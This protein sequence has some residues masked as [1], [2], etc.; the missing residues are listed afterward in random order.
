MF[1]SA[2]MKLT[3]I[4]NL[5]CSYCYM[6]NLHDRTFQRVPTYLPVEIAVLTLDRVKDYMEE[7]ALPS[8]TLVLHGGEPTLWPLESFRTF[9]EHLS[10]MRAKGTDIRVTIQTNAYQVNWRVLDLLKSHGITLGISLD[11]PQEYNDRHRVNHAGRGSYDQINRNVADMIERGYGNLIAGFLSVAQPDTPPAH[12]LEWAKTLPVRRLSVLWPIEFN[13]D[14]PPWGTQTLAEYERWPRYGRWFADL[15]ELWWRDPDPDLQIRHFSEVIGIMAGGKRH[16]DSIVND[17]LGMFV[18]NTDGGIEYPD[19]FRSYKDGGSRTSFTIQSHGL[20]QF[21]T[22]PVFDYCLRLGEHLPDECGSCVHR[23][24]C[25]GGFL[26]GRMGGDANPPL[27]KSVLCTDQYHFF[28]RVDALVA[29]EL[30]AL[31]P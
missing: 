29:P 14:N 22:D 30:D 13:H 19:Y 1:S 15:F 8:F 26:P 3:S 20:G 7:N 2:I 16:S 23:K 4:C 24:V 31:R 18:I 28:S 6:F 17:Q 9:L 21:S 5:N 11:G 25:G 10:R 27:K 12:F